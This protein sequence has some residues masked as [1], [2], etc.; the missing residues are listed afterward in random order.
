MSISNLARED[1]F[2]ISQTVDY[3]LRAVVHLASKASSARTTDEIAE[4]TRVPRAY[5]SKVM[6]SL[7]RAGIVHSQ[8][9]I[10][11]GMT[12]TKSA[13]ELTILEVVNAVEPIQR[14]R[15]CPLGLTAHGVRLCPLHKRLDAA[16]ATVEQAF[17]Y[18]TLA[19]I[20]A[21]PTTS[22]P[23]CPFPN[24]KPRRKSTK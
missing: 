18:T 23:L 8:R 6:Q 14:I 17:Q 16:L 3:A 21:E 20:L 4:A 5:L 24:V 11:G 19:E 12:L 2:V 22:I 15:S 1:F 13:A 7:C 10:G 9:G